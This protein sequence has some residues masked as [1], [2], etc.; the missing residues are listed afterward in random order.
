MAQI[1]GHQESISQAQESIKTAFETLD[2]K[3][4]SLDDMRDCLD[5]AINEASGCISWRMN[6][7]SALAFHI[8]HP[9][10]R[11]A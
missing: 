11:K 8:V 4:A 9:S 5:N 6:F 10:K 1:K 3:E 7:I 2:D